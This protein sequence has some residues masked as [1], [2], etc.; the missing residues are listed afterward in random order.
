MIYNEQIILDKSYIPPVN[1]A[2]L[3][4]CFSIFVAMWI[5]VN[6]PAHCRKHLDLFPIIPLVV[7]DFSIFI[8]REKKTYRH[9]YSCNYL[10]SF[11]PFPLRITKLS[12]GFFWQQLPNQ[13]ELYFISVVCP[14]FHWATRLIPLSLKPLFSSS[15]T[16][17]IRIVFFLQEPGRGKSG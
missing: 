5:I 16:F 4:V 9:S 7:V 1:Q 6:A 11:S 10:P 14:I 15:L 17:I 12:C 3:K 8:R 2:V 13:L